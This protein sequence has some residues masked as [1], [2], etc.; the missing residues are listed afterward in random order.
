MAIYQMAEADMPMEIAMKT[1]VSFS[2]ALLIACGA[3]GIVMITKPPV[4]VALPI[5]SIDTYALT[6]KSDPA[7]AESYDCN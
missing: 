3:F 5:S 4:S 2:V 6:L 7:M 1:I